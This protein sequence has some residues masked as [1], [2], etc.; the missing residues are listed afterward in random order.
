MP[1]P[2]FTLRSPF[3]G[4]N[5]YLDVLF[6]DIGKRLRFVKFVATLFGDMTYGFN[7]N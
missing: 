6:P 1:T 5:V 4:E 3:H 7:L 2:K